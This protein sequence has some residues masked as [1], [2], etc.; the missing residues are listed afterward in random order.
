VVPFY[1]LDLECRMG[2]SWSYGEAGSQGNRAMSKWIDDEGMENPLHSVSNW[3]EFDMAAQDVSKEVLDSHQKAIAAFFMRH[4]KKEITEEGLKR[5][6]N[7]C[8]INTPP[9]F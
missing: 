8:A 4:T 1:T 6:L 9:T 7:A 3:E 5:G 2:M